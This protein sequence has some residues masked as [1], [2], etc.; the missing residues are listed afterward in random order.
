MTAAPPV[1]GGAAVSVDAWTGSGPVTGA[2]AADVRPWLGGPFAFA[3]RT[4]RPAPADPWDWRHPDVGWG[5]V[6]RE[7]DGLSQADLVAATDLPADVH[8][9]VAAR[10]GR[11]FRYRP[12]GAYASWTLV[13]HAGGAQPFLPASPA[14]ADAGEL[15]AFLLIYGSPAD[16]PWS[17]QYILN[18]VRYV[19]RLD[20]EGPALTRYVDAVLDDW[21]GS[22]AQW[23]APVVWAVDHQA[24]EI[25]TLMR[26]VVAEPLARA[27]G[28]DAELAPTFLD[29]RVAPATV[30]GL[31][32][33]LTQHRPAVVVTSS[34]GQTGPLGDLAAMGADLGKPVDQQHALLDPDALLRSWDPDGAIW[35]AQACCSAGADS[36]S[37]YDRLFTGDLAATFA[38]VAALGAVTSPLPRALLGAP[39]P[40]RAFVGHVEPTLDWTLAFPPNVQPLTS[41]LRAALYERLFLGRPVGYAMEPWYRPIGAL[42]QGYQAAERENQTTFGAAARASLDLMVYS[43]VTAHDRASTVIL[44]DPAVAVPAPPPGG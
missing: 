10:A 22:A 17:V 5:L 7:P 15:P 9:L 31:T 25:T 44:G 38:R 24:G 33:A 11:I 40:L 13:D 20:L 42:L 4:A 3:E 35:F 28:E 27:M 41:Q 39:K 26:D 14:G 23:S 6:A 21:S 30:A 29:G 37:A 19:G 2:F 12:G 16:V 34:H 43:R 18:P 8:R 32:A 1:G 36:P